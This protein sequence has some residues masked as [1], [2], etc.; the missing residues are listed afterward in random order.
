MKKK[1]YPMVYLIT[2]F[3]SLP[4]FVSC[5]DDNDSGNKASSKHIV[6]IV[7][8]VE[9]DKVWIYESDITYDSQGRVV[10]IVTSN[11][12]TSS[13]VSEITYQYG[14]EHILSKEVEGSW[15]ETHTYTLENGLIVKDVRNQNG[16]SKT[17]TYEY[18]NNG[19]MKSL[20]DQSLG[21]TQKFVWKDGNLINIGTRSYTYSNTPW[22]ERMIFYIKGSNMDEALWQSG[23]WGKRPKNLPS[24]YG[25]YSYEYTLTGGLVTKVIN[26]WM[27]RGIEEK[28]I[29]TLVWE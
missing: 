12:G 17:T 21:Y 9:E 5:D 16:S 27:D 14:E 25:D 18:D 13:K 6:K 3:M 24:R 8:E 11:A 22:N 20:T 15:S 1:Y 7:E 10:R 29:S 28:A 19:Y 2:M 23:C 26:K 4:T